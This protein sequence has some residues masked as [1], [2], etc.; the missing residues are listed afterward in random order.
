MNVYLYVKRSGNMNANQIK[1][2]LN[3]LVILMILT[4]HQISKY[5]LELKIKLTLEVI[6]LSQ[7][8]SMP[9]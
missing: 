3:Y 1:I 4:Q 9:H 8:K 6:S 2:F 7:S 5:Y